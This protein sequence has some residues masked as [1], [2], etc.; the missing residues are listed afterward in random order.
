MGVLQKSGLLPG[1]TH[2]RRG[3]LLLH[4]GQVGRVAPGPQVAPEPLVAAEEVA[5]P[6]VADG[7]RLG[8]RRRRRTDGLGQGVGIRWSLLEKKILSA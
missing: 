4:L 6:R 3:L 7:G 5:E 2:S 8:L 1:P